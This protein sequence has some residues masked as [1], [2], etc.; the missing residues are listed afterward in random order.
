MSLQPQTLRL[1]VSDQIAKF[2]F[3]TACFTIMNYRFLSFPPR[4][5]PDEFSLRELLVKVTP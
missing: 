5:F 2:L 4:L 1:A 3:F